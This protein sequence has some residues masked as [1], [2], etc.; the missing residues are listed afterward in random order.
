MEGWTISQFAPA[1]TGDSIK[2]VAFPWT[3]RLRAAAISSPSKHVIRRHRMA[4]QRPGSSLYKLVFPRPCLD[5]PGCSVLPSGVDQG[6]LGVFSAGPCLGASAML[7]NHAFE[8]R[9]KPYASIARCSRSGFV[10]SVIVVVIVISTASFDGVS[11]GGSAH[12]A[13]RGDARRNDSRA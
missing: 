4:N 6:L 2:V 1:S 10:A 5:E 7:R 12:C 8:I 13:A 9:R 3:R 11:S